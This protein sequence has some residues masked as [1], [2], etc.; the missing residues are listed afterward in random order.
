MLLVILLALL[1]GGCSPGHDAELAAIGEARSLAAE[2]AL[3]N[4]E[5]AKGRL[6]PT[7]VA[8]MRGQL[9]QQLKSTAASLVRRD[10]R[11]AIEMHA[12]LREPDDAA[13][14]EL[15]FHVAVLSQIEDR[16]ESA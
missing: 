1:L 13:P 11:Y 10:S 9:R 2:W 4:Q 7:Y 3:L 8:T 6:T 12:L 15:R 16:L 5:A 14:D